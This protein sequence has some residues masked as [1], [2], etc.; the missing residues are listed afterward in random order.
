MVGALLGLLLA[1][2]AVPLQVGRSV[3]VQL[4]DDADRLVYLE[5]RLVSLSQDGF[6]VR[7]VEGTRNVF[8]ADVRHIERRHRERSSAVLHAAGVGLLAGA[9]VGATWAGISNDE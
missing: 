9:L 6:R 1:G 4:V 2:T 8:F 5:G 3:R 7:N